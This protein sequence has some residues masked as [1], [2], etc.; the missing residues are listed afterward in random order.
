MTIKDGMAD[1]HR[2]GQCPVCGA[3][4]GRPCRRRTE[5]GAS[6][7][8]NR[9]PHKG[10]AYESLRCSVLRCNLVPAHPGIHVDAAG[11]EF[12]EYAACAAPN[13]GNPR[14]RCQRRQHPLREGHGALIEDGEL[15]MWP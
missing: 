9:L 5:S 3:W 7:T 6:R 12:A 8:L 13:P 15:V 2:Y 14:V 11:T 4:P 10:R 1:W